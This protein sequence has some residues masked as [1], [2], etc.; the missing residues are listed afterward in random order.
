MTYAGDYIEIEEP[1]GLVEIESTPGYP[2]SVDDVS[3]YFMSWEECKITSFT[4]TTEDTLD[5]TCTL[6]THESGN[7]KSVAGVHLPLVHFWGIGFANMEQ[8]IEIYIQPEIHLPEALNG[9]PEGGTI[10][11]IP[12]RNFGF[13]IEDTASFTAVTVGGQPCEITLLNNTCI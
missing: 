9:S 4:N 5:I 10:L 2:W 3:I 6:P 13:A 7:A 1:I 8:I 11:T 12:G